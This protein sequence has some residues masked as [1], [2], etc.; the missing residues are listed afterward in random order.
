MSILTIRDYGANKLLLWILIV[1]KYT[2]SQGQ[3]QYDLA[4]YTT[5]S[6]RKSFLL[7]LCYKYKK[8]LP[9]IHIINMFFYFRFSL[10]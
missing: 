9:L 4:T 2:L 5:A 7:N 8:L 6:Y 10:F 1:I 3:V